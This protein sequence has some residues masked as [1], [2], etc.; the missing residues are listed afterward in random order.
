MLL[1][2]YNNKNHCFIHIPKNSGKYIRNKIESCDKTKIITKYWYLQNNLDLAHI[3]YIMADKYVENHN[4]Y[5]YFA[6]SRNPYDRIISA[7]LYKDNKKDFFKE[8]C[9][10]ELPMYNFNL[11]FDNN[12]IHYYPQY[13]FVCDKNLIIN[14]VKIQKIEE[15][16]TPKKYNYS[17]YYD[18]KCL[19]IINKIYKKD[20]KLFN[21]HIQTTC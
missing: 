14:N 4:S 7:Y 1:Y 16:A 5:T 2:I 15:I 6:Y 12:I 3:P 10:K 19:E 11:D 13:L 18:D 8:F 20:F 17:E 21:Y 9:K